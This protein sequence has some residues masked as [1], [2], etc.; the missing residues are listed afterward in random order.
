MSGLLQ[1]VG[2]WGVSIVGI[3]LIVS[4]IKDAL[5]YAKGQGNGSIPKIITKVVILV[6]LIG[7]IIMT[8]SNSW[9]AL[10]EALAGKANALGNNIVQNINVTGK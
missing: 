3:L 1:T 5:E 10:G 6:F 2:T 7:V 4:I 9:N 8:A